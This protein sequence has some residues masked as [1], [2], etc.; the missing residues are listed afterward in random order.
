MEQKHRDVLRTNRSWLIENIHDLDSITDY[1]L[2]VDI[3]T[4]NMLQ[5]I[6][7][8]KTPNGKKGKFLD[9]LPKRGPKAFLAFCEALKEHDKHVIDKIN[10]SY[11]M[12]SDGPATCRPKVL[13][14]GGTTV[15]QPVSTGAQGTG[16]VPR[17]VS[18]SSTTYAVQPQPEL[19]SSPLAG[20]QE[21]SPFTNLKPADPIIYSPTFCEPL[22]RHADDWPGSSPMIKNKMQVDVNENE[23]LK[24]KNDVYQFENSKNRGN[25][26]II[27]NKSFD[28]TN[29]QERKSADTDS[30][31][32][33][34]ALKELDFKCESK[35]NLS[36]TELKDTISKDVN[37]VG[38]PDVYVLVILSYGGKGTVLCRDGQEVPIQDIVNLLS[39]SN[40][41]SLIG[42]PKLLFIQACGTILKSIDTAAAQAGAGDP[43]YNSLASIE[44]A[45]KNLHVGGDVVDET[46]TRPGS[47][48]DD[49][50]L[51]RTVKNTL[52][53]LVAMSTTPDP[54]SDTSDGSLF[55]TGV[56]YALCQFAHKDH[57]LEILNKVNLLKRKQEGEMCVQ[58]GAAQSKCVKLC[59]V[60]HSLTKYLYFMPG[61]VPEERQYPAAE[62]P[63]VTSGDF[64]PVHKAGK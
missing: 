59:S 15:P 57:I 44:N 11:W 61:Y 7:A 22:F 16:H 28:D 48:S 18:Y 34:Y 55:I 24:H 35:K 9:F 60:R 63:Q 41:P 50:E 31:N 46:D 23:K 42:R 49:S 53:I 58:A 17:P 14:A 5:E 36:A 1:L 27:Y 47:T 3:I 2:G 20:S 25:A 21:E 52:D 54:P 56:A 6:N 8:Q 12:G 64:H 38:Q 10:P 19:V 26:L 39:A 37:N 32:I 29:L 30:Y 13:N 62:E 43:S 33:K 45:M 51:E 4:E 40:C